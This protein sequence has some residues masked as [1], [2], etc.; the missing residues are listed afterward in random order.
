MS[1][2]WIKSRD[3]CEVLLWLWRP[4]WHTR[5]LGSKTGQRLLQIV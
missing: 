1:S 3:F 5:S 4:P 2:E